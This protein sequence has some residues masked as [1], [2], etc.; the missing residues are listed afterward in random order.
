MHAKQNIDFHMEIMKGYKRWVKI[1]RNSG[2]KCTSFVDS[3][4]GLTKEIFTFY[5]AY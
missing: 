3:V 1:R 5:V 4:Q 2:R